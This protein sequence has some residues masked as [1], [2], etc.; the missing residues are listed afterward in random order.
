MKP[1]PDRLVLQY[2]YGN[3]PLILGI[4]AVKSE[5]WPWVPGA[6]GQCFSIGPKARIHSV[7]VADE[8]IL[9]TCPGQLDQSGGPWNQTCFVF[10]RFHWV[11]Q[12]HNGSLITRRPSL[13]QWTFAL[14][15]FAVSQ[16]SPFAPWCPNGPLITGGPSVSPWSFG[17]MQ[18]CSVSM[19]PWVNGVPKHHNGP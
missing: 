7:S 2:S 17:S 16:W 13:S 14:W 3:N 12:C 10:L 6:E 5:F 19:N 8:K 4:L 9:S 18:S 15:G 1:Q 11:L